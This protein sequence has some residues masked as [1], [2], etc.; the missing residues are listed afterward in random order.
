M[1]GING[2]A[3]VAKI[4]FLIVLILVLIVGGMLWVDF[5]GLVDARETLS[6]IL[7]LVRL[8]VPEAVEQPD[9]MY[10]LD[11]ERLAKQ[12][13][14][15]DIREAAL[16][17]REE[18]IVLREAE[19]EELGGQL[20]ES[21]KSIEEKEKS[22]NEALKTYDNKRANLEQNAKYLEGMPPENAV[23]IMV[24]MQDTELVELLRTSERLAVESGKA[25][26]VA[27]WL[28]LMPAD[29]AAELQSKMALKPV[30]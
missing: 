4:F 2:G 8:D 6:P 19:L 16:T 10:L 27:Y 13:E 21:K 17:A 1:A 18:G 14:A 3:G 5:L 15:L 23:S 9:D 29:R 28:S 12:Q 25:S 11:R 30:D 7:K 22:L 20:E 24:E 26:L